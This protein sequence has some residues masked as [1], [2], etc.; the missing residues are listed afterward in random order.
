[1]REPGC[2]TWLASRVAVDQLKLLA[3]DCVTIFSQIG[4]DPLTVGFAHRS[5]RPGKIADDAH[6]DD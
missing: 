3:T 5:K 4:L 2:I 1:L 6:L